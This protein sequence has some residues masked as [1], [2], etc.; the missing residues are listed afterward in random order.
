MGPS[1]PRGAYLTM[2][3]ALLLVS[4]VSVFVMLLVGCRLRLVP[5][6]HENQLVGFLFLSESCKK[7]GIILTGV[8][9]EIF[10][11]LHRF[12]YHGYFAIHMERRRPCIR[13]DR[14]IFFSCSGSM[15]Y[16]ITE[17]C[18]LSILS[19]IVMKNPS[20]TFLQTGF[21]ADHWSGVRM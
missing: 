21:S 15:L 17:V 12:L 14:C 4:R 9:N 3:G 20:T 7:P 8:W 18:H 5:Y 10:W 16:Q 19:E 13:G 11:T 1:S 2:R 6:W